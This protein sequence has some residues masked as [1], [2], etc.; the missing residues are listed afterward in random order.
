MAAIVAVAA[1]AIG[2]WAPGRDGRQLRPVRRM[3]SRH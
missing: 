1:V 3:L 2:V